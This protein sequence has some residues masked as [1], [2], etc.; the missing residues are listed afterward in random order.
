MIKRKLLGSVVLTPVRFS[1]HTGRAITVSASKRL[2]WASK[3]RTEDSKG[4]KRISNRLTKSSKPPKRSSRQLIH[5]IVFSSLHAY[6]AMCPIIRHNATK[7]AQ[8]CVITAPRQVPGGRGKDSLI[9]TGLLPALAV[10]SAN[11]YLDKSVTIIYNYMFLS[12]C[13]S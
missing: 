2:K 8:E 3:R 1:A 6:P 4:L 5:S 9:F 10:L 11:T 12:P 7:T 13:P